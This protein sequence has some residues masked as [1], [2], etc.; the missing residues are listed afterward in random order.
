MSRVVYRLASADELPVGVWERLVDFA[1]ECHRSLPLTRARP[2][3]L[4][5]EAS[6]RDQ[7]TLPDSRLWTRQDR[8]DGFLTV[9]E[10]VWLRIGPGRSE[11]DLARTLAHELRHAYQQER[12]QDIMT[13]ALPMPDYWRHPAEVDARAWSAHAVVP[14]TCAVTLRDAFAAA[15][16]QW[17]LETAQAGLTAAFAKA[18]SELAR[19]EAV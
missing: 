12:G 10:T 18:A 3:G 13:A 5:A 6:A 14:Y 4:Y 15:E 7:A 11:A 16:R 19:E 9:G 2:I 8:E 1:V 17:V